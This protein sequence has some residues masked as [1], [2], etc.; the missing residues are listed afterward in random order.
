MSTTDF[1][2]DAKFEFG[3]VVSQ[4]FGLV[5]RNFI[6]FLVLSLF[7]VGAPQFGILY[8]QYTVGVGDP[9]LLFPLVWGGILISMIT[10][11]VLQG[12]LTRAAI[13]DLSGNGV[14][15][16]A[17]I[18][19]GLRY[20]FPLLIVGIL[21]GLG[22]GLGFILL[23]VPGIMLAVR[24]VVSAPIV[25]VEKEGPTSALGRA[26][27]LT[28]G[29]RWA[30]FGLVLLY[31]VLS[32]VAQILVGLLVAAVAGQDQSMVGNIALASLVLAVSMALM[33]ALLSLVSTLGTASLYFELRRVKEGV[34]VDDLAKVFD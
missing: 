4:T 30:I 13:D 32:Y 22:T 26:A 9:S 33:T 23:V 31:F 12:A 10:T 8:A 11:F 29:N 20:F 3:R 14:K 17:A 16:G 27:E 7:F 25:V 28:K 24:W 1:S 18:A 19:D 15:F 34:S 5:G 21:A 2:P 6:P